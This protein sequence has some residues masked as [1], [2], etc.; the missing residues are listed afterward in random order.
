V[1]AGCGEPWGLDKETALRLGRVLGSGLSAG[2]ICGAVSAAG[3][4]LGLVQGPIGPDDPQARGRVK[5]QNREFQ[6][7]FRARHGSIVCRELLGVDPND[8]DAFD[9]AID[10]GHF[11]ARCASFV[12]SAAELLEDMLGPGPDPA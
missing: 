8:R 11:K 12:A 2:D 1:L 6:R 5:E 9:G 4:V 10:R 3:M 7:R